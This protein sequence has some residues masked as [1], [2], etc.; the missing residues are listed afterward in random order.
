MVQASLNDISMYA[1]SNK[2]DLIELRTYNSNVICILSLKP[3]DDSAILYQLVS[4]L[5][6][7]L[8]IYSEVAFINY[9]HVK[10]GNVPIDKSVIVYTL[11]T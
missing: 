5:L 11:I 4:D 10:A 9:F 2:N 6:T 8:M 1:N 3:S 7:Q